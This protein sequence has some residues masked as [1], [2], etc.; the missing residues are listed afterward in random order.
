MS[1]YS[2]MLI[3]VR[4]IGVKDQQKVTRVLPSRRPV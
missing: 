4:K 1:D 3:S 2:I